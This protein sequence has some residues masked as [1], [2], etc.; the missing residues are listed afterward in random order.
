LLEANPQIIYL[1]IS[2]YGASGPYRDLP[3][4]DFQYL[5]FA[6]AIPPPESYFAADY[7]PTT[8]PAADMGASLY[9]LLAV[10]LAL[11]E[12]LASPA[13]FAGRHLDVAISDCTLALMEP[14]IAEALSEQTSDDAP[15]RPVY[16]L[17]RR[18]GGRSVTIGAL[19]DHFWERLVRALQ[20]EELSGGRFARYQQRR[21]H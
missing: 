15:A 16:G 20:L 4:H 12:K 7:V 1:S 11:Y 18:A 2:G 5:S 21:R 13:S 9:S 19:E 10:V 8:L 17:S 3:G 14:R 6:G